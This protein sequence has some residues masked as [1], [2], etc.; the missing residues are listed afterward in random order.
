MVKLIIFFRQPADVDAFEEH[1]ANRHVPLISEMP[2]VVRSSVTRAVGAPRGEPAY[3]IIHDVYFADLPSLTFALNSAPGRA[4]GADLM[5]FAR[6]LVTLMYAEVWGEDPFE[7]GLGAAGEPLPLDEP[8]VSATEAGAKPGLVPIDVSFLENPPAATSAASATPTATA[9]E[10]AVEESGQQGQMAEAEALP[11]PA[12]A[13]DDD[14]SSMASS[15]S[16]STST[17]AVTPAAMPTD[18]PVP[19]PP[20]PPPPK[21]EET[22]G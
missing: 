10:V 3:Y 1:F 16:T 7:L 6:D 18:T 22:P 17:S 20:R 12:Q 5:A 14:A 2:N 9:T 4:A 11:N 13:M 21:S 19:E 15:A 8:E